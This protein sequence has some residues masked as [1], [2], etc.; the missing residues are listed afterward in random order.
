ME[1]LYVNPY[2]YMNF[3]S[4]TW[5]DLDTYVYIHLYIYMFIYISYIADVSNRA[6]PWKTY[7]WIHIF[8][9]LMLTH[10]CMYISLCVYTYED[11]Y[12]CTNVYSYI[13]DV[14]NPAKPWK[15]YMWWLGGVMEEFYNQGTHVCICIHMFM[16]VYRYAYVDP[17]G[18][19][20]WDLDVCIKRIFVHI[21]MLDR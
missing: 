5:M 19:R 10:T 4:Y 1:D 8:M 12:W 21:Y 3:N 9:I 7:M 14:S 13:A 11:S 17:L 2:I 20:C 6:K 18:S 15:T 16:Y